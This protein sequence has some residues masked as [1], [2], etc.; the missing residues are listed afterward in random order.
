MET[1]IAN[2]DI[3]KIQ[4]RSRRSN[5]SKS[6]SKMI[7]RSRSKKSKIFRRSKRS[8]SNRMGSPWSLKKVDPNISRDL[9]V[10]KPSI[11]SRIPRIFSRN[12]STPQRD[13][14]IR[15]GEQEK[16]DKEML[17]YKQAYER[18]FRERED[19]DTLNLC[20]YDKEYRNKHFEDCSG[21]LERKGIYLAPQRPEK[22]R[23]AVLEEYVEPTYVSRPIPITRP[24]PRPIREPL[25]SEPISVYEPTRESEP[26]LSIIDRAINNISRDNDF[27]QQ[28][29]ERRPSFET[30]SEPV[31]RESE[32]TRS[33][34]TRP[35]FDL[36]GL[37]GPR[38]LRH[39]EEPTS[40]YKSGPSS[41]PRLDLSGLSQSMLKPSTRFEEVYKKPV[42]SL[43][44]AMDERRK[45][46]RE[47]EDL[48]EDLDE[49]WMD[50]GKDHLKKSKKSKKSKILKKSKKSK[51]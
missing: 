26:R 29:R 36:S 1:E 31:I 33:E 46:I 3:T 28:I 38:T 22:F 47:D 45:H 7:K 18:K 42:S 48:D 34:F 13:P 11:F 49:N 51:K 27:L 12:K 23:K 6:R 40:T 50:F 14:Y 2:I 5:K 24:R 21:L 4:K 37:S 15:S 43:E 20:K 10:K 41:G 39:V 16:F 19:L 30:R 35:K 32:P 17:G 44:K 9:K 25:I 8:R